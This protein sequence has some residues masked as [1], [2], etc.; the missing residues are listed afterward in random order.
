MMKFLNEQKVFRISGIDLGGQPGRRRTVMIGSIGYPRH[1]IVEDRVEGRCRPGAFEKCVEGFNAAALET[2]TPSALMLFAETPQAIRAHLQK[3]A[4]LTSVPLLLDSPSAEVRLAG[5]RSAEEMGIGDRVIYNSIHAGTTIEELGQIQDAK[6]KSA[7]LLAFNPG[8]IG[9]KGKIYLLED[10][11]GLLAMGMI[12]MAKKYGITMP[13]LDT[14]VMTSDQMAGSA[15]RAIVIAK[16]KWGL[17]TGCAM[18]NAVDSYIQKAGLKEDDKPLYRYVDVSSAT[19]PISAGADY[20]MYGPIEYSR[21]VFHAGA[22]ADEMMS[23]AVL[24]L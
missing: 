4:S 16:A 19:L 24:D 13:I 10:G 7:V 18:H 2:H 22:F 6:V 12:D 5:V 3:A 23:Q 20:V 9:L 15:L 8:D 14:A 17:P 11:G 1:S 21:R